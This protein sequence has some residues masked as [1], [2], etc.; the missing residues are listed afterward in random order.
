MA[1]KKTLLG[2]LLGWLLGIVIT[3]AVIVLGLFAFLKIQYDINLFTTISSVK[4]LNKSY[5]IAEAY[6]YAFTDDDMAAAMTN[7]NSSSI[8][9]VNYSE[10]DGYTI[11]TELASPMI[12]NMNI[13]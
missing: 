11:G 1:K 13:S 3:V 2:R 7:L 8:N 10:E 6:P 12:K 5:N 4:A 9:L